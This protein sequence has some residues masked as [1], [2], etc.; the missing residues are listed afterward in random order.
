MDR[1]EN[2]DREEAFD[3]EAWMAAYR[4]ARRAGRNGPPPQTLAGAC[5]SARLAAE[6]RMADLDFRAMWNRGP[7]H[8]SGA[9]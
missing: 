6:S 4:H 1:H 8:V 2:R 3:R 9:A 5:L 7:R